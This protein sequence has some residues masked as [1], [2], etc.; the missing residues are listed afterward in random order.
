MRCSSTLLRPSM[1]IQQWEQKSFGSFDPAAGEVGAS[2]WTSF[3]L[4]FD[5][6]TG[7]PKSLGSSDPSGPSAG[8]VGASA[9]TSFFLS[10]DLCAGAAGSA[11][12]S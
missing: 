6:C 2:V 1:P 7:A 4:S 3:F 11:S 9:S 12:S 10:F 8:E 5:P